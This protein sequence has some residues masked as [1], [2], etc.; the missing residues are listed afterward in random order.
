MT[1]SDTRNASGTVMTLPLAALITS[2]L[3]PV[4]VARHVQG[5]AT[6]NGIG[7]ACRAGV[8]MDV[9]RSAVAESWW[10]LERSAGDA[11]DP[12][13]VT[14]RETSNDRRQLS[15]RPELL[16]ESLKGDP[17]MAGI[18][19]V[20]GHVQ[21]AIEALAPVS[22]NPRE[23]VGEVKMEVTVRHRV[24][25]QVRT[26]RESREL[27]RTLLGVPVPFDGHSLTVLDAGGLVGEQANGWMQTSVDALTDLSRQIQAA[28]GQ[29]KL[30]DSL[31]GFKSA[32]DPLHD[33][34]ARTIH[35]FP[36]RLA[37]R[38]TDDV[39]DLSRLNLHAALKDK[40]TQIEALGPPPQMPSGS[41]SEAEIKRLTEEA[42]RH[43]TAHQNL[44]TDARWW[45]D[46]NEEIGG[47][48]AETLVAQGGQLAAAEWRKRATFHF[49]GAGAAA[50]FGQMLAGYGAED[51]PVSGVAFVDNGSAPLKLS[52]LAIRGRLI[53]IAT[54]E[55]EIEDVK[56]ADRATDMLVVQAGGRLSV[57]G[58]VEG[59]LI[60]CGG[61]QLAT[62]AVI[63]G[64]LV[65]DRV[66]LGDTF[67]GKLESDVTRIESR[68][69]GQDRP[70]MFWIA[71]AP[72]A[73]AREVEVP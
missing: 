29:L 28:G 61:I 3:L 30:P 17:G 59:A 60:A 20:G 63:K 12:L 6:R 10:R 4:M 24:S 43:A 51:R 37:L 14:F 54:G 19:V 26:L 53:V 7:R 18:E 25:G 55:V 64:A 73:S 1:K 48:E 67:A 50:D 70:E 65:M 2:L 9:A 35:R 31:G 56:V 5:S 33:D 49:E 47:G 41:P 34:L 23:G 66:R 71:F 69:N 8:L 58:R 62:D 57:S 22:A 21:I 39:A 68:V 44:L 45:Q 46:A 52:R 13:F 32:P 15:I 36:A 27:R 42:T 38:R 40:R 72:W 11:A 16:L